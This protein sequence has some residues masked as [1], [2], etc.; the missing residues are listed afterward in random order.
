MAKR[1]S[2]I[3]SSNCNSNNNN[4]NNKKNKNN[5]SRPHINILKLFPFFSLIF[6]V[7]QLYF[8]AFCC[9]VSSFAAAFCVG[10]DIYCFALSKIQKMGEKK[11][12]KEKLETPQ[13]TF[14]FECFS[15]QLF[16]VF[17]MSYVYVLISASP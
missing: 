14:A 11:M 10:L 7:F 9:L 12:E 13:K 5:N 2:I 4:D 16:R 3:T 15:G 8:C 17:F 6:A 1:N